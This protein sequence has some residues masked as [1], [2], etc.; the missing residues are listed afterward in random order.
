M[1]GAVDRCCVRAGVSP[2]QIRRVVVDIGPGGYTAL[3]MAVASAKMIALVGGA[4]CVGVPAAAV[5][6]ESLRL[7]GQSDA[8]AGP[9]VVVLA[10]KGESAFVTRF[11]G[12]APEG[13]GS[14]AMSPDDGRVM[15]WAEVCAIRDLARGVLLMD[16][17]VPKRWHEEAAALGVTVRAPR[18]DAVSL[19]HAG[20][21]LAGD[22][23]QSMDA[24]MLLPLY[25]REPEAV[26]IWRERKANAKQ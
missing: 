12:R 22:G 7:A 1:N 3:R 25:A 2:S 5:A 14:P 9:V 19:L 11:G 17:H 8:P 4:G 6:F 21:R 18:F 26:T 23:D 10:T 16:E 24:S 13:D 15:T 20:A